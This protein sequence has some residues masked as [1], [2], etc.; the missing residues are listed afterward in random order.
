M[1]QVGI[2]GPEHA[3]EGWKRV[4][5]RLAHSLNAFISAGLAWIIVAYIE[6]FQ[7]KGQWPALVNWCRLA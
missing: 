2:P 3:Q 1:L 6:T 4:R 5:S 7:P